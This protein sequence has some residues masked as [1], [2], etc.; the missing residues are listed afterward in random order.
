M[1]RPDITTIQ[2]GVELKRWYWL[3]SELIAYAKQAGVRYDGAKFDLLDRLANQLDGIETNV[4]KSAKVDSGVNWKNRLLTADTIITDTYT[5][6]EN[7]RSFFRAHCGQRFAFSIR[8]M[9]WMKANAGK[10][11]GDA[12]MEWKRLEQL[13]QDPAFRADIPS[14]NQF[15]KY[16]RDFF[17]DNPGKSIED[18]RQCWKRKRSLPLGRHAYERSDLDLPEE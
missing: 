13:K 2:T 12:V 8:F 9:A 10:N 18:A 14:G 5:N 15:N 3:K 11:L 7:S 17:A 16:V 4:V 1:E 6:S